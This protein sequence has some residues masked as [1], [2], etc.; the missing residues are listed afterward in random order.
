MT[1]EKLNLTRELSKTCYPT[2]KIPCETFIKC[3]SKAR[4]TQQE[5]TLVFQEFSCMGICSVIPSSNF[6]E[7]ETFASS[8][9][10]DYA[11]KY[12]ISIG[13]EEDHPAAEAIFQKYEECL[14][15]LLYPKSEFGTP[16]FEFMKIYKDDSLTKIDNGYICQ[17]Y[18]AS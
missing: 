3:A 15:V 14:S 2:M 7:L 11:A 10:K 18:F 13:V 12:F 6:S 9:I 8:Y 5:K 1:I 17:Y 4:E 16:V